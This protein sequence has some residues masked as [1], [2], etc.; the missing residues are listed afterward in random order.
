MVDLYVPHWTL[1]K[2]NKIGVRTTDFK[3]MSSKNVVDDNII[4]DRTAL[5]KFSDWLTAFL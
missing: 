3:A 2:T 4:F 1:T 5:K